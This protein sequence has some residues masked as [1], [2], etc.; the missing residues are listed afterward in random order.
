MEPGLLSIDDVALSHAL[1][2]F[3]DAI[4]AEHV[5][6]EPERLREFSDPYAPEEWTDLLPGAVLQPGSVEEVQAVVRIAN[7]HRVP[8]FPNSRGKNNGYGG[9]A[10]R[11]PGSAV[12][13]LIRMNRVLEVNEELAYVVVEPGVSFFDL[14]AAVKERGADIWFDCPDLGWGSV[15]GN[16]LEHGIGY[17]LYGDR[18]ASQCGM[19]VVL[20]NGEL[21]RTGPGA[22]EDSPNWHLSKRGFGP[23]LD[24]LFMQSN[25]GIVTKMGLWCM[26]KPERF[27]SGLIGV[28]RDEDLEP[29]VS[30]VRKLMLECTIEGQPMLFS[31]LGALSLYIT[32]DQL[33]DGEGLI[34]AEHLLER[35][36]ALGIGAWNLRFA[37]WGRAGRVDHQLEIIREAMSS[38]EGSTVNVNSYDDAP[39]EEALQA[40][41]VHAGVPSQDYLRM[42]DF[43]YGPHRPAGHVCFASI[44][45]STGHDVRAIVELAREEITA[46]GIDYGVGMVV[47]PRYFTVLHLPMYPLD[48]TAAAQEAHDLVRRLIPRAAELGYSEYR[49][50]VS[51]MDL[52]AEQLGYNDHALMRCE[53]VIKDA[54]D[55]N[56]VIAP[57]KSGIWPSAMRQDGGQ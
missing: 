54:L 30:A 52:V 49:A 18:A 28:P 4:G 48:D 43:P 23:S 12:V 34:P 41:K 15:L 53:Q 22:M 2:D 56:G 26:P 10:P 42:L 24:G 20:P 6:T 7:K 11:V 13:N 17:T 36:R 27:V 16:V 5:F 35:A 55:P 33:Y 46:S 32:R 8:L 14:Q 19:E 57:G 25:M 39:G 47:H 50:H 38:I 29:F 45:P 51:M 21:L 1:E 37:L 9:A 40:D 31:P 44:V 3:A